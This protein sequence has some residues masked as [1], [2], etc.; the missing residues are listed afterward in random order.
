[1]REAH[2]A[3]ANLQCSSGKDEGPG[4]VLVY[5]YQIL[6]FGFLCRGFAACCFE[7]NVS[8]C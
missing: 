7:T 5:T 6:T 4:K 3:A 2:R 1:V 8:F